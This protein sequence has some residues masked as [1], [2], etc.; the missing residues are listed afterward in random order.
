MAAESQI[1]H[2]CLI[3]SVVDLDLSVCVG[4]FGL[5]D[6]YIHVVFAFM[7]CHFAMHVVHFTC[8]YIESTELSALCLSFLQ[9]KC[10]CGPSFLNHV[11]CYCDFIHH[12]DGSLLATTHRLPHSLKSVFVALINFHLYYCACVHGRLC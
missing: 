6:S 8:T 7:F 11:L 4:G 1:T 2:A 9:G 5:F 12:L 3:A 10:F